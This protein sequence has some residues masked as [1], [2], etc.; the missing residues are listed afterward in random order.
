MMKKLFIFRSILAFL[1]ACSSQESGFSKKIDALIDEKSD[2]P[3]SGVILI[4]KGVN[5]I[6]TIWNNE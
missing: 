3:F 1:T 5:T 4:T 6:Y 2:K